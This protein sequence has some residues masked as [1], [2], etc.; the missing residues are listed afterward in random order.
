MTRETHSSFHAVKDLHKPPKAFVGH[1]ARWDWKAWA[2]SLPG[3]PMAKPREIQ[4]TGASHGPQQ[5]FWEQGWQRQAKRLAWVIDK[6]WVW[7]EPMVP[8]RQHGGGQAQAELGPSCAAGSWGGLGSRVSW[9]TEFPQAVF[10]L[11]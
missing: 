9:E 7:E 6:V 10:E 8:H 11:L 1:Q 4:T 5:S 2:A 3:V